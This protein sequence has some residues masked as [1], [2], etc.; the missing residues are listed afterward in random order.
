MAIYWTQRPCRRCGAVA[1]VELKDVYDS[2][3][4][5]IETLEVTKKCRGG[6]L[7]NGV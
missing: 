5:V 7:G 2:S 6:C 1:D 4:T 3:G